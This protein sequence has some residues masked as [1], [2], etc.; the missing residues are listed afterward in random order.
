MLL[1]K[2]IPMFLRG[3]SEIVRER[4]CANSSGLLGFLAAWIWLYS[5]YFNYYYVAD[6]G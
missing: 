3:E 4:W 6:A 1:Y 5:R 2:E